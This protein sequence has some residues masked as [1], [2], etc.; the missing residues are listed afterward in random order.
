MRGPE[1]RSLR[2]LERDIDLGEDGRFVVRVAG[3]ADEISDEQARFVGAHRR[4]GSRRLEL[5]LQ[6]RGQRRVGA[7]V[8][9][10]GDLVEI[11]RATSIPT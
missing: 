8:D 1:D 5:R 2:V 11:H 7:L 10:A 4:I 6:H 9:G 3:P